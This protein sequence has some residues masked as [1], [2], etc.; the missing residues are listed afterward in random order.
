MKLSI[1]LNVLPKRSHIQKEFPEKQE[2]VVGDEYFA[3]AYSE[4]G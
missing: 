3:P 4:L 2:G 1:A